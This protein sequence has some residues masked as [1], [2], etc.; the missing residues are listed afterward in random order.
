MFDP[1]EEPHTQ[2]FFV[3]Q[4]KCTVQENFEGRTVKCTKLMIDNKELLTTNEKFKDDNAKLT[5]QL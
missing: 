3:T 4:S 1:L 2:N 5:D